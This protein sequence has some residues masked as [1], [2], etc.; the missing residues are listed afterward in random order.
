MNKKRFYI[1]IISLATL[2]SL[3]FA[4]NLKRQQPLNESLT[5]CLFKQV[6]SLPCPAC[7]TTR[8]ALF[9]ANGDL[10]LAISTNPLGLLAF[11]G[12]LLL[13]LWLLFDVMSGKPTLY[14]LSE[15]L[16]LQLR[17]PIYAYSLVALIL[18]NWGWNIIKGL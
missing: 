2:G 11:A 6:S 17:K 7:G 14:N 4:F 13:P 1:I 9:I 5:I 10:N 8:S 12:I 18:I 3:W 16:N 15:K